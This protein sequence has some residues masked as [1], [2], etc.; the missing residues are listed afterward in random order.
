M[1]SWLLLVRASAMG[2][3][4]I[5]DKPLY[6]LPEPEDKDEKLERKTRINVSGTIFETWQSTLDRYPYTLLGSSERE[7]FYNEVTHE[8]FF[9]R[10][11]Q[12]FRYILNYYRTGRLH[13][14]KQECVSIYENELNFFGIRPDALEICCYE[15]YMEKK[16][17]DA[18]RFVTIKEELSF[19]YTKL[20]SFR[21]RLWFAFENP[22]F[23]TLGQVLY[24][25]SGFFIAL[26]VLAN[27]IETVTYSVS[28]D[29]GLPVSC[30]VQFERAFFC[31]DTGCV[32]IFTVEYFARLYAAPNRCKF[33]KSSMSIIDV[34]A[35]L[36]YYIG[37]FM[38]T[39]VSGAFTT[40][41]VFRVFRIFK[42]SRH[43]QGLRILGYTLKSCASELGFLL[44]SMSMAIIIFATIMYYAEKSEAS[45]FTSIPAASWYTIVTMTTLG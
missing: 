36:P 14:P 19:D 3:S 34:V 45:Q 31:L 27:I 33:A 13:F 8:Y 6:S 15:D 7:Y 9:D 43:S 17:E 11:P 44:F 23:T 12:V 10:D 35:V 37:L 21:E 22:H 5:L 28:P 2:W 42:F 40:L 30:G 39:N 25:V 18:D 4:P 1:Y 24:Y 16:K 32:L 38:T 26:S 20:N 29:T 41:R